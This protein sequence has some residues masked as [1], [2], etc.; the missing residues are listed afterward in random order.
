MNGV[1]GFLCIV[2][3]CVLMACSPLFDAPIEIMGAIVAGF[4]TVLAGLAL[5][6]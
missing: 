2:G 5:V 3:G 6:E 1:L 4:V